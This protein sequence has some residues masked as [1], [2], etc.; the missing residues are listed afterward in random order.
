V[1]ASRATPCIVVFL[2]PQM[3]LALTSNWPVTSIA[4]NGQTYKPV[5]PAWSG[6]YDWLRDSSSRLLGVRYHPCEQTAF[7]LKQAAGLNYA[8]LGSHGDVSLFFSNQRSFDPK[9]SADQDFLYDQVFVA[10]DGS[11]AISFAK[12]LTPEE[13]GYLKST[14]AHWPDVRILYGPR[15]P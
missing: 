4:L 15:D 10:N 11:A 5:G 7:V 14:A 1:N 2:M 12:D 6:F 3:R 9:R 13:L 8:Q